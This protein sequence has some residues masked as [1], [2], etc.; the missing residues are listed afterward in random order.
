MPSFCKFKCTN[1]A[2]LKDYS[3]GR[4]CIEM[5][6]EPENFLFVQMLIV[7]IANEI[8]KAEVWKL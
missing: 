8:S 4:T 5:A 7:Y 1:N 2:Y 6:L 3:S